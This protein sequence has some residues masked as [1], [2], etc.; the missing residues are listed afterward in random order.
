MSEKLPIRQDGRSQSVAGQIPGVDGEMEQGQVSDPVLRAQWQAQREEA[1]LL[2][3]EAEDLIR[4]RPMPLPV[5]LPPPL[6]R[7]SGN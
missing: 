3:Q 2:R 5:P 6:I 1:T 7:P 4:P